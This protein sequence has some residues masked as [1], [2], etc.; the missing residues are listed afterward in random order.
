MDVVVRRDLRE[1]AQLVVGQPL[2]GA[3]AEP[4][5]RAHLLTGREHRDHALRSPPAG[6]ELTLLRPLTAARLARGRR[7]VTA[8]AVEERDPVRCAPQVVVDLVV[9]LPVEQRGRGG[10]DE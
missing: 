10:P 6:V 7:V 9:E 8:G 5:H 2:L 4:D 3:G 1:H